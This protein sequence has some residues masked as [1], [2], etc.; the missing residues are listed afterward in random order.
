MVGE[1]VWRWIIWGGG[2]GGREGDYMP[3]AAL[4]PAMIAILMFRKCEGQNLKSVSIDHN[5]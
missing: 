1:R 2:G 4:S 3:I 5:F